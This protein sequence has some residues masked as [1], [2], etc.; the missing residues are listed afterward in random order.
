MKNVAL[1]GSEE[2]VLDLNN[3]T[4]FMKEVPPEYMQCVIVLGASDS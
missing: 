3:V 2:V 4:I 1:T